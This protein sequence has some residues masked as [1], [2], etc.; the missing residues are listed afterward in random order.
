MVIP[1]FYRH[2]HHQL[3]RYIFDITSVLSF[4][5]FLTGVST[6][7]MTAA[8]VTFKTMYKEEDLVVIKLLVWDEYK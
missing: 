7:M 8:Y 4:L 1:I 5:F 2:G 6:S 3:L